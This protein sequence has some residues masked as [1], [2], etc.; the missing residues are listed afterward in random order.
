[1][2]INIYSANNI[3]DITERYAIDWT[4]KTRKLRVA[5][6]WW[7]EMMG[8]FLIDEQDMESD[9]KEFRGLK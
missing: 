4:E 3:A 5:S 9:F 6:K 1:M 8:S 7:T 2:N